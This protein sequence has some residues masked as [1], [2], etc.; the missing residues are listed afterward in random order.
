[1]EGEFFCLFVILFVCLLLAVLGVHCCAG[2]VVVTGG[3][4]LVTEQGF[5]TAT[6]SLCFQEPLCSTWDLP[7]L[8]I[9]P[10]LLHGQ[11]DPLSLSHK[12]SPVEGEFSDL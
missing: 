1:M 7:G 5:L 11:A 9:E 6:A 4:S 2:L 12:E 8:G 10:Q 3:Y